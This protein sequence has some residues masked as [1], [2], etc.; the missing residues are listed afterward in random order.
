MADDPSS[1]PHS[2]LA[3][4]LL[5][6]APSPILAADGA[7][8]IVGY[9]NR[10]FCLLMDKPAEQI[11][12]QPFCKLLPDMQDCAKLLTRVYQS[13]KSESYT[14]QQ[15]SQPHPSSGPIRFGPRW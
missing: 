3:S 2:D 5:E 4:R 12:G 13:G 14:E 15:Y 8:H 6:H 9:V 7:E 11:I 1:P 10:A